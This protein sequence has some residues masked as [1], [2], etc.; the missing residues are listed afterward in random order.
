M[1]ID[2]VR[3]ALRTHGIEPEVLEFPAGT[4]TAEEA[5]RAVDTT[6][7]QIVK[8]LVF[9]ADGRPVLAL[10]SG[11]NRVDLQ[12]LARA[13]G[14]RTVTKADAETVRE[15]T[16]FAIG[17]VP[18]VG[19]RQPLP[20]VMDRD[21]LPHPVVY[22]AAGTPQAVFPIAPGRLC[23][24][25][26]AAVVDLREDRGG[27][28]TVLEFEALRR[29]LREVQTV[30]VVGLSADEDAESYGV[31]AYL[32]QA[33]YRIIPVNPRYAGQ[34]ILGERVYASLREVPVPVDI[35]DVFR[36]SDG[37]PPI[38]EDALALSPRPKL[39]WMQVGIE[40]PEAARRLEAAG[41][42]VVQNVCLR[43]TH[44]LLALG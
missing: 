26:G 10:V 42:P 36:R 29:L 18:P 43:A 17:G 41:I 30:A 22:A 4:R 19:H 13:V 27:G 11:A 20:V 24:L 35:V 1:A 21:L 16:G 44:R 5:A 23:D 34:E 2:R 33:G 38:A 31:A 14:A 12:K 8:S 3:Q 40:H 28:R 39:F 32:Q 37:V 6:P 7:A 15:A 9:L 25:T